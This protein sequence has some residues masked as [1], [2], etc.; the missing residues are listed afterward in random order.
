MTPAPRRTAEE[1]H[2]MLP[3]SNKLSALAPSVTLQVD[4]RAKEPAVR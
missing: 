2:T 1:I 4:A 3:L